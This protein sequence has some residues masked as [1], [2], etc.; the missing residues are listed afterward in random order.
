MAINE[1]L[2]TGR[3]FRQCIDN[4]PG[5]KKWNV[6]SWWTKA[7]D[8]E[9][10]DGTTA[11]TKLGAFKGVTTNENQT[12]GYAADVTLLKSVKTH[13]S[14]LITSLTNLVNSINYRLGG[15]RFYEDSTGKYVVGADSVPKKL[16][17]D[18]NV[19][20]DI[21]G[22]DGFIELGRKNSHE[23]GAAF[24]FQI[25]LVSYPGYQ[26]LTA[27]NFIFEVIDIQFGVYHSGNQTEYYV[28]GAGCS[29]NKVYREYDA[30]TGIL[31]INPNRSKGT[32]NDGTY[33]DRNCNLGS[34]GVQYFK[35]KV[36]LKSN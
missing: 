8:V 9:F 23:N 18:V 20:D 35:A 33:P 27:D 21:I 19:L 3:K 7:K 32:Y 14:N 22:N 11:E 13:L 6:F 17:S 25:N 31:T 4:T 24:P 26:N 34:A 5:N 2:Y 28:S 10:E 36:Y 1:T 15:L 12:A 30:S 16:G 29:V